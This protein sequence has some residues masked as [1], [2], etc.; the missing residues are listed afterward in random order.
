MKKLLILM[1]VLGFASAASAAVT[2]VYDNT[3]QGNDPTANIAAPGDQI[4]VTLG[5]DA[6]GAGGNTG[7]S[8]D[9][10]ECTGGTTWQ[11]ATGWLMGAPIGSVAALAPNG[12]TLSW[13]DSIF[14]MPAPAQD[15]LAITF[16]I[17]V[18]TTA[19]FSVT[20]NGA[21]ETANPP[22]GSTILVPEPITIVL[23]GL[24]GLFLRR[25]K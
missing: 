11:S 15:Y 1:L 12:Q 25:R 19:D 23:L 14:A 8:I 16:N 22:A 7:L 24:G 10:A 2:I 5:L 4:T 17:P 3:T 9:V 13:T 18:T 20:F 21:F 6:M